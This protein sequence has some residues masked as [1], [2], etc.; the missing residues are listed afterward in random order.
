MIPISLI[1]IFCVFMETLCRSMNQRACTDC[2][3]SIEGF[4]WLTCVFYSFFKI[5]QHQNIGVIH[6][7]WIFLLLFKKSEDLE[8]W[9]HILTWHHQLKLS[10]SCPFDG[11]GASQFVI[12]HPLTSSFI[13][14]QQ[15]LWASSLGILDMNTVGTQGYSQE[16]IIQNVSQ[17]FSPYLS[18]KEHI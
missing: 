6:I 2:P 8:I 9:V 14:P 12:I 18:L 15:S 7:I 5:C 4:I 3:A 11:A 16:Q 17:S 13:L 1:Y 10:H